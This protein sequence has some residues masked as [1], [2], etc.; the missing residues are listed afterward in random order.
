MICNPCTKI[1]PIPCC[2]DILTIGTISDID[3]DVN[4]YIKNITTN[5]ILILPGHADHDGL[6][7]VGVIDEQFASNQSYEIWVTKASE[8]MNN[9]L[10][11]TIGESSSI[12]CLAA[13][14]LKVKTE[15]D[16]IDNQATF[17]IT[18]P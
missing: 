1:N 11:L 17:T 6:V 12:T 16:E 2:L 18:L 4:V 8:D 14:Y 7:T 3:I 9:R 5:R 10:N 15:E 13:T